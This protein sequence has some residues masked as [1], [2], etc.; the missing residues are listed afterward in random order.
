MMEKSCEG[1]VRA[2]GSAEPVP[3]GGAASALGGALGT[4]SGQ[5]V[6]SLAKGKRKYANVQEDIERL[7]AR[8]EAAAARM[9]WLAEA[10]AEAFLP[11]SRVYALPAGTPEERAHKEAEMEQALRKAASVPMEMMEEG[12]EALSALRE[13]SE[14]GSRLAL[15]DAGVGAAF[16]RA[17]VQGA[18][19]NVYANTRLMK[20]RRYAEECEGKADSLRERAE[21]E[22]DAI[23]RY[24]EERLRWQS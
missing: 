21:K 11:L 24:V 10:D 13:T 20:D 3:G 14:K 1:F 2:L 6:A 19:M 15:S 7:S 23:Y 5:M 16:L 22:A 12:L 4:A 8:L 18:A 9:L 17:S